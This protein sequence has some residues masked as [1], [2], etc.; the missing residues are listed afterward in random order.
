MRDG[1]KYNM[2]YHKTVVLVRSGSFCQTFDDAALVVS[3]LT[4]Y[5]VIQQKNNHVRCGFSLKLVPKIKHLLVLDHISYVELQTSPSNEQ[6]EI[7]DSYDKGDDDAFD[8]LRDKG[9]EIVRAKRRA[10]EMLSAI[11]QEFDASDSPC[12]QED[13]TKSE[14]W[15]FIDAL[16][17]GLHPFTGKKIRN[18][19]LNEPD[20]IR[21]L[22]RVRE[23]L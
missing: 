12:Q 14:E 23:L 18:L 7:L 9:R 10:D 11:R 3:A 13:S 2:E 17:R 6:A 16:C 5:Q 19:N 15:Q 20:I 1:H 21:T 8:A 4:D 22:F